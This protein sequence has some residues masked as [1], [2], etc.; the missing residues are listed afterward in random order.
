M[1]SDHC[2][3][4]NAN[5]AQVSIR[6]EV[7]GGFRRTFSRTIGVSLVSIR[8]EVRGGSRPTFFVVRGEESILFQS[9]LRFAVVPD[10]CGPGRALRSHVSI[11][12]EVRG[13]SRQYCTSLKRNMKLVSIRFEV[14]G[15]SR[16]GYRLSLPEGTQ[17]SIRFEVRGGS[18][19]RRECFLCES[20]VGCFNPL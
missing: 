2:D 4:R 9:A 1:V 3:H 17:V 13:G 16:P 8:F 6:F 20:L 7:R 10:T 11:R 12:F 18:R 15:G 19:R 5:V 14:R